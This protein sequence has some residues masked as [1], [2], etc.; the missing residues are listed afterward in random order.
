MTQIKRILANHVLIRKNNAGFS[1]TS[2]FYAHLSMNET[3]SRIYSVLDSILTALP[4]TFHLHVSHNPQL[5]TYSQLK[6]LSAFSY[7]K[8]I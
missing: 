1:N 5:G 3:E 7:L 8:T 6:K 2:F 4:I